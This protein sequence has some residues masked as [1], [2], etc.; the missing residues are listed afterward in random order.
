M[1]HDDD[2]EKKKNSKHSGSL[3]IVALP[4]T[5]A[6]LSQ[7]HDQ[8]PPPQQHDHHHPSTNYTIS[9]KHTYANKFDTKYKCI[10]DLRMPTS[11]K[12]TQPNIFD[13]QAQISTSQKILFIGDSVGIQFSQ[14][15]QEAAGVLNSLGRKILRYSWGD[16]EG[17]HL[18]HSVRGGGVIAG[19]RITGMLRESKKNDIETMPNIAGGGWLMDDVTNLKRALYMTKSSKETGKLTNMTCTYREGLTTTNTTSS[20]VIDSTTCQEDSFDTVVLQIPFGWLKKPATNEIHYDS[21]HEAVQLSHKLFG[22]K[23]VIIQTIPVNNNVIDMVEELDAINNAIFNYSNSYNYTMLAHNQNYDMVEQVV[24]MDMAK[25]SY[26][27][28]AHNA[29]G[30]KMINYNNKEIDEFIANGRLSTILNPLIS[31]RTK[32][33]NTD[34]GQIIA[35]ACSRVREARKPKKCWNTLYSLDGMHWCM[36]KVGGKINGAVACLVQCLENKW[37]FGKLKDCENVC[38]HNFMS[39][40]QQ[41]DL[42]L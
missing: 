31:K 40:K 11:S 25:F 14:S 19:W 15:L 1:S 32:C 28:F 27:L 39:M 20:I 8:S 30:L 21:I 33:C 37:K 34:Y 13:F 10:Q 36:D 9:H 35:F 6:P 7:E 38:N 23:A 12:F 17:I 26:E 2:V 4:A 3:G 41:V 16:H 5:K 22:A 24:V 42:D 18:A 29:A